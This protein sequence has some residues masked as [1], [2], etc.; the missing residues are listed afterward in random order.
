VRNS[1]NKYIHIAYIYPSKVG[2]LQKCRIVEQTEMYF[3]AGEGCLRMF[4]RHDYGQEN[5]LEKVDELDIS[6]D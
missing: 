3:L 5:Y 6:K 4:R 1:T 2:N